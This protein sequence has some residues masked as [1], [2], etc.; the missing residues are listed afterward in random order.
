MQVDLREE[1]VNTHTEDQKNQSVQERH[2]CEK[3]MVVAGTYTS[4]YMRAMMIET[5]NAVSTVTA[6]HG[7][8]RP[9]DET[10]LTKLHHLDS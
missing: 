3:R 1:L 7:T 2:K 9:E 6:V 10:S 4:A 5:H 8:L